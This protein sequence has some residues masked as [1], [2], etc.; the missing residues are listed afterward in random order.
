MVYKILRKIPSDH[1]H[2][3]LEE[4][5][6]R[7]NHRRF[8]APDPLQFLYNYHDPRDREVVGFIAAVLAYGRVGHIIKKEKI[9]LER[10]GPR[11]ANFLAS[12]ST[13]KI[14]KVSSGIRHR[15]TGEYEIAALLSA[16]RA[17]LRRHGS[18]FACFR[19]CLRER[20]TTLEP[21]LDRFVEQIAGASPVLTR[22]TLPRPCNGSA[23][24]RLNLFLRWMVRRDGVDPGDWH[25]LGPSLLIVPLDTH[26]FRIGHALGFTRRRQADIIAAHEI[27]EGFKRLSPEDPV[28]YDFVLT[29]FGIRPDFSGFV[30]IPAV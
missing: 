29:R 25:D 15:F 10:L 23:C 2:T 28:R 18:L 19:A 11:P 6:L 12:S 26:M 21:A 7:Y 1:I 27:T 30:K 4:L 14:Q 9:L 20:E 24:K 16:I 5:Y 3:F 17:A 13:S 8:V 22:F